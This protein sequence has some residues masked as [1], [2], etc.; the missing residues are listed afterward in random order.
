MKKVL[1]IVLS[2]AFVLGVFAGCS[3]S[4][5]SDSGTSSNVPAASVNEGGSEA[6]ASSEPVKFTAATTTQ[7]GSL[8]PFGINHGT[9]QAIRGAIYE[10]LFW[11]DYDGEL[12]GILA[13]G[14]EYLGDGV[15]EIELFDYI[16]D[17][18]GN[19]LTASDVIYS[20]DL[21]IADGKGSRN[22]G[23][24]TS[25]EATGDYTVRL[26]FENEQMGAFEKCVTYC[27][28]VTQA[29]WEASPDEMYS[30]PVG[31]GRY[32]MT[33]FVADSWYEM[34][35]R[36]D[37]WQTDESRICDKNSGRVDIF[38]VEIVADA[39]TLAVALETGE[40]DFA[41]KEILDADRVNFLAAD[42]SALPGY[43]VEQLPT[44]ANAHI[45]FNCSQ[46]SPCSD[47]N[48]RKAICYAID[49]AAIAQNVQGVYGYVGTSCLVPSVS[50]A[51]ES[52]NAHD[53]YFNYSVE[54]AKE[55]LEKSGYNGETLTLLVKPNEWTWQS[56]ILIEAYCNA[57][58]INIK[59]EQPET[60]LYNEMRLDETGTKYDMDLTGMNASDGYAWKALIDL[61]S[62]GSN[63]GV[64][65]IMTSD[66]KLDELYRKAAMKAT[67]GV[68]A[69]N[70]LVQ[71]VDEQCY[72][73]NIF[74]Y[75]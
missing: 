35:K 49:A 25:Y 31:T 5:T 2:L 3:G 39:T 33:D 36:D 45:T 60:A 59:L 54:L 62:S 73:Y 71:Y 19:P 27:Y 9:K 1:A 26:T 51:D 11:E 72:F 63:T 74:Y 42:G 44:T 22:Y 37:Y 50:D 4:K 47:V 67:G 66:A 15:Y 70:E 61:D 12:H 55:Y 24:L 69:A 46:N 10:P 29:A 40:I 17:S 6:N 38:R 32:V 30:T 21:W 34:T 14:Y 52:L 43:T 64:S 8:Y 18:A 58:G 20:I 48:L 57:I 53:D 41:T 7:M 65:R 68:E 56:A 13:K 28:C 75:P 23:T 16:K